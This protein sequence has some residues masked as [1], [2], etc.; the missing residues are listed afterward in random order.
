MLA[1][2][3]KCA[4]FRFNGMKS[5]LRELIQSLRRE[6]LRFFGMYAPIRS[7]RVAMY[8]KAGIHIGKP[9]EFGSHIYLDLNFKNL[10]VIE[11]NVLLAGY[12]QILT[13]SFVLFGYE[14]EGFTPVVIKKGARIGINV[15]ILSGVTIGENSVIGAG[16]V[17]TS[18]IPPNCL[19]VGVP[20]KP[21]RYFKSPPTDEEYLPSKPTMLYVRCKTCKR[22][23]WSAIQCEKNLF[24]T[25]DLNKNR[26][27]CPFCGHKDLYYKKDY[28]FK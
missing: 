6:L 1:L 12:D 8:R 16:S 15:C 4:R 27:P 23:F 21:I 3:K 24:E 28:Y 17:V 11:D 5:L 22:E 7:I 26:H 25:L 10:I 18:N 13:H 20:A 19:A 9:A 14:H 2:V